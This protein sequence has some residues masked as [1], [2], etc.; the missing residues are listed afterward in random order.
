MEDKGEGGF[1][2]GMFPNRR[3]KWDRIPQRIHRQRRSSCWRIISRFEDDDN[4][5]WEV[6]SNRIKVKMGN[7]VSFWFNDL[8]WVICIFCSRGCFMWS[9]IKNLSILKSV[10]VWMFL[11]K[12]Q[13][14]ESFVRLVSLRMSL[15]NFLTYIYQHFYLQGSNG[16]SH[17]KIVPIF[18]IMSV[19][20]AF[21][22]FFHML[23]LGL[24][25]FGWGFLLVSGDLE[26]VHYGRP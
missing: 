1:W 15:L 7:R 8:A 14:K 20:L 12:C 17:L 25:T 6:F 16:C 24:S 21:G 3:D 5:K 18:S 19:Y 13:S 4:V 26:D 9:W 10:S 22:S 2:G 11:G 23:I